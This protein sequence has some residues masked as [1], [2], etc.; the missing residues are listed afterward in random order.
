MNNNASPV[1]MIVVGMLI[2]AGLMTLMFEGG[3]FVWV[4][5]VGAL[6]IAWAFAPKLG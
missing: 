2:V 6:L 5:V 1:G 3:W 4:P